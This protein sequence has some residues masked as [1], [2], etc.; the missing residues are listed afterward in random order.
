MEMTWLCLA[1][2]GC[3]GSGLT[4]T[5]ATAQQAPE[6]PDLHGIWRI[7]FILD[8]LPFWDTSATPPRARVLTTFQDSVVIG[9]LVVY[10]DSSGHRLPFRTEFAADFRPVL[11]RPMS[12]YRPGTGVL[13]ARR[14]DGAVWLDFG[15]RSFDCGLVAV[16]QLVGDTLR[17]R[18]YEDK[19]AGARGRV[20]MVRLRDR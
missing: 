15:P 12:C 16:G 13:D 3:L 19:P 18:W 2:L 6:R 4:G 11:G 1:L 7:Q 5:A 14:R 17:G 9:V 20:E 8:S 10:P